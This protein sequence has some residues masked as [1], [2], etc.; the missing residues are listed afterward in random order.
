MTKEIFNLILDYTISSNTYGNYN[1]KF[2]IKVFETFNKEKDL[3]YE[4]VTTRL[5]RKG[6]KYQEPDWKE[7]ETKENNLT[8]EEEEGL[9]KW[10]TKD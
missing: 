6:H 8:K 3:S 7:M 9:S 10:L 5:T 2:F 1:Q 4:E